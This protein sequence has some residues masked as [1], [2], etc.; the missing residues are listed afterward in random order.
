MHISLNQILSNPQF[1]ALKDKFFQA[2]TPMQQKVVAAVTATFTLALVTF[3]VVRCVRHRRASKIETKVELLPKDKTVVV[4][5]ADKGVKTNKDVKA[6]ENDEVESESKV[7]TPAPISRKEQLKK[8]RDERRVARAK[9]EA[10][11]VHSMAII[12]HPNF[13]LNSAP[14]IEVNKEAV[15]H[16]Q[17]AQNAFVRALLSPRVLFVPQAAP[18][19]APEAAPQVEVAPQAAPKVEVEVAPEVPARPSI[20]NKANKLIIDQIFDQHQMFLDKKRQ[21]LAEQR[22]ARIAAARVQ[23]QPQPQPQQGFFGRLFGNLVS[24]F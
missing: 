16:A 5:G 15:A 18:E 21:E 9:E 6:T 4:D 3:A 12:V 10:E 24:A 8:E 19:A 13:P 22:E 17:L 11:K 1:Q 14:K 2:L 7:E 23:P 20:D